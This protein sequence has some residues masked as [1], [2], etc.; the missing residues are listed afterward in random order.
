M[1]SEILNTK[2]LKKRFEMWLP[3]TASSIGVA[4]EDLPTVHLKPIKRALA[5]INQSSSRWECST[6]Y[7]TE[8]KSV[9]KR[10]YDGLM[11][12]FFP[13]SLRRR[14]HSKTF[15][16]QWSLSALLHLAINPPDFVG[17]LSG[18]GGILLL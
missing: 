10:N 15:G 2:R 12:W 6:V 7:L 11:N 1:V 5:R 16:R 3:F 13:I 9:L 8:R 4:E 14:N 18:G 17:L